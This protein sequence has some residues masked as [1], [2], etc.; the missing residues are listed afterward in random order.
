MHRTKLLK[1]VSLLGALLAIAV[2]LSPTATVTAGQTKS[3]I[4]HVTNVPA[5][6]DGVVINIADPAWDAHAAH[7]DRKIDP[8]DPLVTDNEDGTCHVSTAPAAPV[9]VDDEVTTPVDT[10]V[11]INVL[12]NDIYVDL[13][14]VVLQL[15]P[16]AG[17]VGPWDGGTITY[18]PDP[19]FL[20]TDSFTYQICDTSDQCDTATVTITVGP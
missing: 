3:D 11:N 9:A 16:S 1:T 12:A 4:C 14:S 15:G 6:G 18:Y 10:P 13:A 17:Q 20:G 5:E 7:G 19:G 2:A 8:T